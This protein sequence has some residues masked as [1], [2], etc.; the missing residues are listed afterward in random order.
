MTREKHKA[1]VLDSWAYIAYLQDEASAEKIGDLIGNAH[2]TGI[3]LL[4]TVV[5]AGE[6]WYS[7]ARK[8]SESEANRSISDLADLGVEIVDAGWELTYE[9]ARF[10]VRGRIAYAD[11]FAAALA[12]RER[13]ILVTGDPEFKALETEVTIR[14]V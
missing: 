14:W 3:P 5:N 4:M 13:G 10:K 8:I 6:V 11:C 9:A 1:V 7:I 12:K 2:E